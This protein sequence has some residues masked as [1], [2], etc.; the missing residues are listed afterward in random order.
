MDTEEIRKRLWKQTRALVIAGVLVYLGD[1]IL[2]PT[3][4]RTEGGY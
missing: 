2:S 1:S 3:I 4:P